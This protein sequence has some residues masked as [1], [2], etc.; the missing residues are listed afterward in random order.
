M[1][2]TF[3]EI[4]FGGFTG[5]LKPKVGSLRQ[6]HLVRGPVTLPQSPGLVRDTT[7]NIIVRELFLVGVAMRSH[8][9]RSRLQ[10]SPPAIIENPFASPVAW[11]TMPP[12]V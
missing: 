7:L 2:A 9:T 12:L 4:W 1:V 8:G 6:Y 10:G 11:V 3:L 5:F